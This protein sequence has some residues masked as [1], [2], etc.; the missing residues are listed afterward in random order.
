MNSIIPVSSSRYPAWK[1]CRI[2]NAWVDDL[3][4][5]QVVD[6]LDEGI[7]WTLNPDHLYHLQ[8][9]ADFVEAYR[10]AAIVSSDSKYVYWG[11][12]FLGRAIQSKASGSDIVPAYW[13]RHADNPDVRIF[14]LG[15]K[16]GIAE[17]A[18][19]RINGIAGREVVVGAHGP[20][21]NF[22]NDPGETAEAIRMINECKATC[23]IVGLGAPK[24]EIWIVRNRHLMPTVKV[25]MGVGATIDYEAQAVVRAP[26]WMAQNGLEWVYRMV[27]EPRRYWRRYARTLEFF[28]LVL[29]DRLGLYRPPA[30]LGQTIAVANEVKAA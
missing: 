30:K 2:L 20:S 28:W 15:A 3:M 26:Q 13:R 7:L 23:L 21:M 14:M 6:R 12:K 5:E 1:K 19:Q 8:R 22:V 27:T 16:P 18:R 10:Q 24:Q 11:L 29:F 9:N 4:V 17:Q 25:C